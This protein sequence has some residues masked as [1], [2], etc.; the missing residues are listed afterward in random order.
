MADPYEGGPQPRVSSRISPQSKRVLK[1]EVGAAAIWDL[2][3]WFEG[4]WAESRDYKQELI[5][6][7][8]TSKFGNKEYT[9]YQ[10]YLKALFEFFRADLDAAGGVPSDLYSLNLA[11]F[12]SDAVERARRILA[13]YDGVMVCDSVGLDAS[14]LGEAINPKVFN[15]IKRI[16]SEDVTVI[17][18]EEA[19]A[20]L[21]SD[22]G[23]V[24]HLAEFIKTSGGQLLKELPDGIHSGMHKAEHR[25][26][27]LY[28]QRPGKTPADTDHFWRYCDTATGEIETNRLAIADLIRCQPNEPRLVDPA[29]KAEIHQIM[30]TVEQKIVE[31]AQ[32]QESI[33]AAPKELSSDQSA[34]MVAL[35]QAMNR[36]DLGRQRVINLLTIL[37]CPMLSAPVKE[38]RHAMLRY[39]RDGDAAS[40]VATCETIAL[41]FAPQPAPGL[42][43]AD[44]MVRPALTR[45]ELR[46]IC[47]EFLS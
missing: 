45:Q 12:Q 22:E 34:V 37:S 17:D 18:E 31:S 5:D 19:E 44:T 16:E 10:V 20:E 29:L 6:L 26:V 47:F 14:V 43:A 9:P 13:K 39:R 35:Q 3:D 7:L 41:K 32:H 28:Y 1:A 42:E 23:L 40:F 2:A 38:L 4:Q 46:L 11:E 30:E 27:F 15:T 33:Q 24:R 21:A 36:P 8:D 25:G